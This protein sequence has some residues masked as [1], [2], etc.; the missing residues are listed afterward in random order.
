MSIFL[1]GPQCGPIIGPLLGGALAEADWRWMFGFLA[2]SGFL[3]WALILFCLP[4]TLRARV[5]SGRIYNESPKFFWPPRLSSPLAPSWERGPAPPKPTLK[6]YWNLFIYPPIGIVT[7]NTA[8]LYSTY[9]AISVNLPIILSEEYKWRTV[10]IGGGFGAVG[11]ALILGSLL[12]GRVSDWRRAGAAKK[13][14]DG[15]VDPEFRLVDQIWG[16][17]VC[18]GGTIMYGWVC[19]FRGHP[20]LILLATF[21]G[22]FLSRMHAAF[23]SSLTLVSWLRHELGVCNDNGLLD[24]VRRSTSC[25][26]VCSG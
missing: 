10:E 9:F 4:E 25:R 21:L 8:M 15:K 12:G 17:L 2:I 23:V 5:G 14:P 11:V 18:V 24:R 7:I 16:V 3:L 13:A 20:A 22:K 26:C 6:G 19:E 1:M